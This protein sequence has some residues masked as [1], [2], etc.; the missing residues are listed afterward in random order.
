MK[1]FCESLRENANNIID[2]NK[3][4]MVPLTIE[5]LK[6]HQ[7]AKI[8]YTCGKRI[9]KVESKNYRKVRDHWY[10]TG[11][12]RGK[13]CSTF[14]LKFNVPN[15]IPV[16]FMTVQVMKIFS[17]SKKEE[18]IKINKDDNENLV[19]ISYK[20]MFTDSARF[21]ATSLSKLVD[22]LRDGIHKIK[23]KH[24]DCFLD[25]ESVMDNLMKNKCLTCNKTFSNQID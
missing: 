6:L 16:D 5:E 14:N 20:I 13:E 22:N 15:E 2:F 21:M 18:V 17:I 4:T 3:K 9:L 12:Y 11:K 19:A 24:C 25:Y 8:Y 23:C 10:Y 7:N 1:R